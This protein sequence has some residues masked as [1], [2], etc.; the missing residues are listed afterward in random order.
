M[1]RE[2]NGLLV[3]GARHLLG[4]KEHAISTSRVSRR[5]PG[6]GKL[7]GGAAAACVRAARP[8]VRHSGYQGITAS[9]TGRRQSGRHQAT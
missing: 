7:F 6:G 2:T 9:G 5:R 1:G 3:K 4:Q 8:G